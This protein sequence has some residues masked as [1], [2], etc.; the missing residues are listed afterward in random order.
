VALAL[1]SV[2]SGARADDVADEL[3]AGA[4][5]SSSAP[6]A[7]PFVSNRISGSA[8]ATEELALSLDATVTRYFKANRIPGETIY[9]L[10]GAADYSPNDHWAFGL[11]ARGSPA[12]TTVTRTSAGAVRSRTSLLGAG[13]SA[14]YDTAGEGPFETIADSAL[15]VSSY[16]TTQR[17]RL[18]GQTTPA[19]LAQYRV[20][21]GLTEVFW[22]DTE[23][24][25]AGS[26]YAYS[27]DPVNTG[28]FGTSVFGR[29]ALSEGLPLEP[30]RWSIRPT[31]RQRLGIVKLSAFFQ[32]GRYVGNAG[33]S[34]T[35]G[36]KAQF[37]VSPDVR[38][39]AAADF[40]RDAENGGETLT[41]PW[42]S[43][44]VRVFL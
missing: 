41:I 19:S 3:T 11:D 18:T 34:V 17:A 29:D 25:L 14:E 33:S 28:Y 40:Q 7:S 4:I 26:W 37:R 16:S 9:Q 8:D 20:S 31:V 27:T 12:S 24:E 39:W 1:F 43:L 22:D 6:G 2:S 44:G 15:S 32:Y 42:A 36:I 21:L 13:I 35:T 5:S 38:L 10:A 30:L 23:G